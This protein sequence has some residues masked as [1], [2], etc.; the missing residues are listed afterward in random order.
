MFRISLVLFLVVCLQSVICADVPDQK[1]ID[2]IIERES[3]GE[4]NPDAAFNESELAYGCLQIRQIYVDDVNEH[5]GTSYEA[6]DCLNN[7][8]LS[9]WIFTKY[10]ERWATRKRLGRTPTYEDMARIHNGGPNGHRQKSTIE[11]WEAVRSK[12]E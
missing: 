8:D 1:L 6:K 5:F 12:M 2:A 10:M 4:K 9:I 3:G 11:Y 7:R